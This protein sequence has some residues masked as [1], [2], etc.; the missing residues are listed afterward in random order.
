MPFPLNINVFFVREMIELLMAK[1]E[2]TETEVLE[3]E[4][5]FIAANPTG[6]ISKE[7]FILSMKVTSWDSRQP[8]LRDISIHLRKHKTKWWSSK[9]FDH[10]HH[11]HSHHKYCC[12]QDVFLAES[13][14]RVF[15]EDKSGALNF[16]EFL[17]VSSDQISSDQLGPGSDPITQILKLSW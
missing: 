10:K 17:Q 16:Y 3:A 2:L 12:L 4:K 5:N 1:C 15:D 8:S 13:L 7:E 6:V 9:S 11:S 14:F